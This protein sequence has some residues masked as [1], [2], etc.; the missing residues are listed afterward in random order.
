M[1]DRLSIPS[2]TAT[3]R[4]F[5]ASEFQGESRTTRTGEPLSTVV[6]MPSVPSPWRPLPE[7]VELEVSVPSSGVPADLADGDIVELRDVVLRAA[8]RK[9]GAPYL[10]AAASA[11]VI[12]DAA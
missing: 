8:V 2:M 10:S 5:F 12:E 9:S 7:L 6:V 3:A 1:S 11:V 4:G